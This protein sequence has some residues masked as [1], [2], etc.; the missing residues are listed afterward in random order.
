MKFLAILA[1]LASLAAAATAQTLAINNPTTGTVWTVGQPSFV[2]WTGNCTALGAQASNVSVELVN[3]PSTAVRFVAD[4]GTLDCSGSNTRANVVVP[5]TVDT[6][7]YSVRVLTNPN[8][9]SPQFEVINPNRTTTSTTAPASTSTSTTTS[10]PVI[11]PTTPPRNAGNEL[12][13]GS[14]TVLFGCV[15]GAALQLLV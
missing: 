6:G 1:I 3:G 14:F 2:G 12:K 10:T 15:A 11:S 5:N 4:L 9:Y 7:T 8:S 13:A